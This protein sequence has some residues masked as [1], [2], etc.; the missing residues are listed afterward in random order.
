M[1]QLKLRL[2]ALGSLMIVVGML[3]SVPTARAESS[4]DA[5]CSNRILRG[6]YGFAIEGVIIGFGPLRGVAMTHFDGAGKLRQVDH[7][8]VNG[9][10]PAVDWNPG[11]GTYTVNVDCTGTA[12][13]NNAQGP[14]INLRF[15]VVRE[16]KEIHTVVND[17]GYATTSVGVKV[18]GS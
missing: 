4:D 9:I 1:K 3:G 8:V 14:Q 2:S 13:I 16:G 17:P 5:A 7:V 12:Q 6:D 15:V 10:P 18:E 11:T